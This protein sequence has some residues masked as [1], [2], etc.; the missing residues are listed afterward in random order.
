MK[1]KLSDVESKTKIPALL[2]Q[3]IANIPII[4]DFLDYKIEKRYEYTNNT[5]KNNNLRNLLKCDVYLTQCIVPWIWVLASEFS[6]NVNTLKYVK[7]VVFKWKQ[8]SSPQWLQTISLQIIN[9]RLYTWNRNDFDLKL[10]TNLKEIRYEEEVTCWNYPKTIRKIVYFRTPRCSSEE[11]HSSKS[12]FFTTLLPP[13]LTSLTFPDNF[14][15]PIMDN[16]SLTKLNFGYH[17]NYPLPFLP[18]LIK[19]TLGDIFNQ[20]LIL[21]ISLLSFEFGKSFNCPF[22]IPPNLTRLVMGEAFNQIVVLPISLR[23]FVMGDSFDQPIDSLTNLQELTVGK[24]YSYSLDPLLVH[25]RSLKI[26]GPFNQSLGILPK[27]L[28]KLHINGSFNQPI[29]IIPANLRKLYLCGDFNEYLGTFPRSLTK[30]ILGD[31][32]DKPIDILPS[33]VMR[34]KIGN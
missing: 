30:L 1:R 33:N 21:P 4:L 5:N 16:E 22:Q 25:L 23:K 15:F 6:P 10:F 9:M 34:I 31:N 26:L 29:E 18:N 7:N 17:F 32:F 8:T 2:Y 13:N 24:A 20:D 28:I 19:L 11:W 27:T 14:N 12:S 3:I